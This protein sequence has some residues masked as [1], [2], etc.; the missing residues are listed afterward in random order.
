[1]IITFLFNLRLAVAIKAAVSLYKGLFLSLLREQV[2]ESLCGLSSRMFQARLIW[3]GCF[4]SFYFFFL[5]GGKKE[6]K[7]LSMEVRSWTCFFLQLRYK[8]R[9]KKKNKEKKRNYISWD[10][11]AFGITFNLL[12]FI[13]L[14]L[15]EWIRIS[16]LRNEYVSISQKI[17]HK[18]WQGAELVQLVNCNE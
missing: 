1:M 8:I 14:Y 5:R 18:A 11:A 3:A 4:Y 12:V 17:K 10:N 2:E 15:K 16:R 6:E 9:G 7:K 13:N